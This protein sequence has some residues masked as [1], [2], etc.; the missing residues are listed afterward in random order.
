MVKK[1]MDENQTDTFLSSH[2]LPSLRT[3]QA[4]MVFRFMRHMDTSSRSS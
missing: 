2:M 4:L 1:V 3:G